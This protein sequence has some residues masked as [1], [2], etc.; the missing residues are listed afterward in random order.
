M[1]NIK[2]YIPACVKN[3]ARRVRS[4]LYQL[5][6]KG[7]LGNL[8]GPND[9]SVLTSAPVTDAESAVGQT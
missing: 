9:Q 2:Q 5:P 3:Y 6:T 1:M 4:R 7:A 8:S